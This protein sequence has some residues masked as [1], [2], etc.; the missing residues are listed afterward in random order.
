VNCNSVSRIQ[1]LAEAM[2]RYIA[3][4]HWQIQRSE[5]R[6]FWRWLK[7]EQNAS[8]NVEASNLQKV[9]PAA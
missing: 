4:Q 1:A 6:R 5:A 7:R 8:Y 9:D 3:W 2:E